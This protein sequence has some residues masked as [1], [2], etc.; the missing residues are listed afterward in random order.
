MI[1]TPSTIVNLVERDEPLRLLG[2]RLRAAAA[3]RGNTVLITGEAGIGK[4]SLLRAFAETSADARLWWGA[5]DALQTPHPLAPLYDIARSSD[6]SFGLQ[7]QIDGNRAALFESV[8]GELQLTRRPT[9]FVVEDAHWA[10]EATLDL[11]IFVGRRIDRVPCLLAVSYR[12]DEFASGHPL[13]RLIGE[14]P[15]RNLARIELS[16]FSPEAVAMLARRA[17]QSPKDIYETTGGNPFFVTELLRGAPEAM[18]HS[19]QDLVLG[20]FARLTTNAQSIARLTSIV[21]RHIERRLVETL[22]PID[23]HAVDECLN[24]GLLEAD[25]ATLR[26]R[27]ELARVVI[28]NSMSKPAAEALHRR[29][30][31]ALVEGSA[32]EAPAARLAHHATRARDAA[33]ILRYGPLAAREAA[34]RRAHREAAVHY[35]AA[36]AC[37]ESAQCAERIFWLEAYARECQFT[38]QLSE[39]IHALETAHELQR[40]AGDVIGEGRNLSELALAYVRAL[41]IAE[42]DATI[43]QAV[44][45]LEAQAPC[46]ELAHAYRVHAH[47]R[48][49]D[50]EFDEAIAKSQKAIE[51]AQQFGGRDILAA[52]LGVFGSSMQ[53]VDYE[54]GCKHLRDAFEI[55]VH[56][57]LDFMAAVIGNNLGSGSVELFRFKEARE[58]LLQAI[59][60]ARQHDID[61]ASAFATSWLAICEMYLGRW[62]EAADYA[63]EVIEGTDRTISRVIALVALARVKIRRGDP[64]AQAL[65]D[66][67]R[68]LVA[69]SNAL[70]RVGPVRAACAEAALLRG[71]AASVVAEALPVLRLIAQH[72][73][74]WVGA[75]LTY[76]MTRVGASDMPCAPLVE[77]FKLQIEGHFREAAAAWA[78]LGC[79]YEQARALA[80]GDTEAQLEALEIFERLGA[81]PAAR[82]LRRQLRDTAV[83]GVPRGSRASTHANPHKLTE[84]ELE[85][86]VLLCEGLKNSEIADRLCRSVRTVD[87]HVAAAFAKMGVSNRTEAAAEALKIGIAQLKG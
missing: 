10:D 40:S 42:A 47:L 2:D 25:A 3:G 29:V 70:Q 35:G 67:A 26:F 53:F 9:L 33:A 41:R 84:R 16:R 24:S 57:G 39:A 85:V 86:V 65:L 76:L 31:E 48:M 20:R 59:A 7:F 21:P 61:S 77:P 6:V 60:F 17:L 54:A 52:A 58:Q 69:S 37:P 30:L 36:L 34:R 8:I 66:Q 49:L 44:A 23:L 15:A 63:R 82:A 28:E 1:S 64:D 79:P 5:C 50:G 19:I 80:E 73:H 38:A 27:H 81:L 78:H 22:L 43:A 18:P 32:D 55:A 11:L 83:R 13:Q 74:E 72:G 45:L 87:H 51:L 12:D 75:E 62:Q 46:L 4:T 56:E 14:L 71:D 68:S